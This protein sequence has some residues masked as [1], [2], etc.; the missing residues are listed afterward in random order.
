M[1]RLAL[2]CDL[3]TAWPF[4]VEGEAFAHRFINSLWGFYTNLFLTTLSNLP[5]KAFELR[6]RAWVAPVLDSLLQ[7]I[8][9]Q[10]QL[11]I[12]LDLLCQYLSCRWG[13]TRRSCLGEVEAK[14]STKVRAHNLLYFIFVLTSCLNWMLH[15]SGWVDAMGPCQVESSS[16]KR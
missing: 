7:H 10:F 4:A 2:N 9:C 3:A 1:P 16:S 15:C 11:L 13:G 14:L 6:F 8:R 5:H 12:L